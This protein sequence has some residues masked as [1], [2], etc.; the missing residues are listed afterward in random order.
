MRLTIRRKSYFRLAAFLVRGLIVLRRESGGRKQEEM[1][2]MQ[3]TFV[4]AS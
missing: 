3:F 1:G 4:S 2:V